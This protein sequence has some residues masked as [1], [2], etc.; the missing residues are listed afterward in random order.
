MTRTK[1]IS[2]LYF[3]PAR[4]FP[5]IFLSRTVWNPVK[6]LQ[7]RNII[8]PWPFRIYHLESIL[9]CIRTI[10]ASI[11]Y[12]IQ[13]AKLLTMYRARKPELCKI[14][15]TR[16]RSFSGFNNRRILKTAETPTTACTLKTAGT[17]T[18]EGT[19]TTVETTGTEGI[20]TIEQQ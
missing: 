3:F 18:T 7:D 1:K 5:K 13:L 9:I 17:P 10:P 20:S 15:S 12:I 11:S 16:R 8:L 2:F 6:R 19:L 4:Q 14:F